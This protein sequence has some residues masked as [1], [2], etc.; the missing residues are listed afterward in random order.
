MRALTLALLLTLA[1]AGAACASIEGCNQVVTPDLQPVGLLSLNFQQEHRAIGSPTIM[2]AEIGVTKYLDLCLTRDFTPNQWSLGFE[3]GW[4][5]GPHLFAAGFQNWACGPGGSVAPQPFAEYGY[6]SH[7]HEAAAGAT[8][9]S[10]RAETILAYTYQASPTWQFLTD[11]QSGSE[12][13]ATLGV[14]YAF[15]PHLSLSPALWR[16]NIAPH[17]AFSI[18]ILTWS[19]KVF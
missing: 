17:R 2:Q 7:A 3:T 6:A 11:W 10:G 16:E 9:V 19:V 1:A 4:Q 14:A 12:N 8:W 18:A 5:H 15:T 13:F